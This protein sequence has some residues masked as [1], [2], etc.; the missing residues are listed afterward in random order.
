MAEPRTASVSRQTAETDIELKLVVGILVGVG[1][2]VEP[3][4][5]LKM[6]LQ[7][8]R[9]FPQSVDIGMNELEGHGS[10]RPAAFEGETQLFGL[11]DW[12]NALSQLS[13]QL[14]A[15]VSNGCR[16]RRGDLNDD[17]AD[18]VHPG[19]LVAKG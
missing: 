7:V 13:G 9:G 16:I 4:I 12:G 10:S 11:R 3:L 2:V 8:G 15:A 6:P 19:F 18:F 14:L 17:L 5:A 1:N